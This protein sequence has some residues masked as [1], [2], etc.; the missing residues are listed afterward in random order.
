MRLREILQVFMHI[1][2]IIAVNET[3]SCR[4]QGHIGEI[5]EKG[6]VHL[7]SYFNTELCLLIFKQDCD[8]AD[9]SQG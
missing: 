4:Y 3:K 6:K 1:L 9:D 2:R 8:Q 7:L 5:I